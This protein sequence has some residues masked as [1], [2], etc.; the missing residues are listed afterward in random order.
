LK[1]EDRKAGKEAC[2]SGCLAQREEQTLRKAGRLEKGA[3]N[4]SFPA[5]LP[6]CF[7]SLPTNRIGMHLPLFT[8]L[9]PQ[10]LSVKNPAFQY[11]HSKRITSR[12]IVR[13]SLKNI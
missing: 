10:L 12:K 7:A 8:S 2:L 4:S 1:Q 11:T 3:G 5:F 6:S 13:L 9:A